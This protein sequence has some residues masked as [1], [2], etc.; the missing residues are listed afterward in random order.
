MNFNLIKEDQKN[1]VIIKPAAFY[2]FKKN[3]GLDE[4]RD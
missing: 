2:T 4:E 1:H 3:G